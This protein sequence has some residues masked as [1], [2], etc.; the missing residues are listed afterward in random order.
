VYYAIS[1]KKNPADDYES[2]ALTTELPALLFVVS[3]FASN[4][5]IQGALPS[6][7]T[8]CH[9]WL[10][11]HLVEFVMPIPH[12]Y[13]IDTI[14]SPLKAGL[15]PRRTALTYFSVVPTVR[16]LKEDFIAQCMLLN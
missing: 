16:S 10:A 6:S 8:S 9:F 14:S 2:S 7:R 13:P 1:A 12:F 3:G 11:S 15:M 5:T 4:A